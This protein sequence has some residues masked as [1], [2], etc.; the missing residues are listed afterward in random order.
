MTFLVN[1]Q[2]FFFKL[3]FSNFTQNFRNFLFSATSEIFCQQKFLVLLGPQGHKHIG[4]GE[5]DGGKLRGAQLRRCSEAW[6]GIVLI[7]AR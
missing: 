7:Q 3:I 4:V 6:R 5:E 2:Q 1:F